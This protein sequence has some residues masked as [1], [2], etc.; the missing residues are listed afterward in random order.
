MT[1]SEVQAEFNRLFHE[2]IAKRTEA[3]EALSAVTDAIP[4]LKAA[5][6]QAR[7]D[8]AKIRADAKAAGVKLPKIAANDGGDQA[9]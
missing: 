6:A 4:R 2:A 5:T 3:Q 8:V 7:A 9:A 1:T